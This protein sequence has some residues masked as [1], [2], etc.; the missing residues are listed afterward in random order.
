VRGKNTPVFTPSVDPKNIVVVINAEKV[1]VS[2][3]KDEQKVYYHHT[4]YP[5]GLKKTTYK[6]L[7]KKDP[8]KIVSHA[9]K[10][11]LPHN[12]LGRK[13]LKRIRIYAGEEHKHQAQIVDRK[14][15]DSKREDV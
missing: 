4:G 9:V 11:M 14:S 3:K 8:C 1:V 10:G 6:E 2:G 15:D 13:L 7:L 5:G 12:K